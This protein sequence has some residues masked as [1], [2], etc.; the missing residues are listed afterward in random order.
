MKDFF[1]KE[2]ILNFLLIAVAAAVGSVVFAPYVAKAQA[3][4]M[5]AK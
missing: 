4:L 3:K 1:S 2:N 5:P